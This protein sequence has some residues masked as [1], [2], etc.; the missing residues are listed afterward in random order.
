MLYKRDNTLISSTLSFN[1]KFLLRLTTS[2]SL[3]LGHVSTL[4]YPRTCRVHSFLPSL[5]FVHVYPT[6]PATPPLFCTLNND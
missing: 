5:L 6:R 2:L 4:V 3:T 1:K